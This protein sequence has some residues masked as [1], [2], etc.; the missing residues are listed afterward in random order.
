[1]Q[2]Q[3]IVQPEFP[4]HLR[5]A[6]APPARCRCRRFTHVVPQGTGAVLEQLTPQPAG[7]RQLPF[8]VARRCP[9]QS[10]RASGVPDGGSAVLEGVAPQLP[11][12]WRA[13]PGNA[14]KSG[15]RGRRGRSPIRRVRP[16]A[17]PDTSRAPRSVRARLAP[18][19]DG[20][21]RWK[22]GR[23]RVRASAKRSPA[24]RHS[25]FSALRL[26]AELQLYINKT[27]CFSWTPMPPQP[28]VRRSGD[29]A[30]LR[31]R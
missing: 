22:S 10:P 13:G 20:L 16:G 26:R 7:D 5:S 27:F 25:K 18:H 24:R 9:V 17:H 12:I 2:G 23:V 19:R 8:L 14:G 3:R 31:T 28:P 11:R 29:A 6:R 1:M 30:V 15:A 4:T 21:G